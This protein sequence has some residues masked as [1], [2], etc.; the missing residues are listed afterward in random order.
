MFT[1]SVLRIVPAKAQ[2]VDSILAFMK[3]AHSLSFAHQQEIAAQKKDIEAFIHQQQ[4]YMVYDAQ[5][6]CGCFG[7]RVVNKAVELTYVYGV[8][9]NQN[10]EGVVADKLLAEVK[11]QALASSFSYLT[12]RATPAQGAF[13]ERNGAKPTGVEERTK[14]VVEYYL[15]VVD[16]PWVDL[17]TAGLVCVK[18]NQLL[19]AFSKNKQAW[20]LPGGK[21]DPGENSQQALIREIEEELSLVLQPKRLTFLTHIVAPAY[22]EKKNILMRQDCYAYD[23]A[24]EP[25]A[26]ANEIGGV[27]YFTQE[28]YIRN[29]IPVPGVLKVFEYLGEIG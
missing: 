2:D 25:I 24:D 29:Q 16:Q 28:E 15:T 3:Q 20:Y 1:P 13:Y 17:P 11:K 12:V 9:M 7:F 10:Q 6:R 26:M 14:A 21:I 22:G 27:Q 19:L 18:G 23:L 5:T 4:F 8:S